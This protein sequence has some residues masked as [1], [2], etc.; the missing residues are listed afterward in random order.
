LEVAELLELARRD[1][2]GPAYLLVGTERFLVE[3]AIAAVR[4]A[5]LGDGPA[6]FN[7]DTF[8]GKGLSG[9]SVVGAARTLPMMAQKRFVLVREGDAMASSELDGLAAYLEGP[10]ESTC[11]LFV[12]EKLDGRTKLAKAAKKRGIVVEAVPLK[13]GALRAF[14]TREARARGHAL[15]AAAAEA[16]LE[17][18]GEDLAALDDAIERLSLYVGEGQPIDVAAVEACVLP[19]RTDSIWALVDGVSDRDG[20]RALRAAS[21]LLADREPPLRILAMVARQLRMIARMRQALAEGQAPQE[22]CR[23]AGA[24]PF[25]ARELARAAKR[26]SQAD[27]RAAFAAVA[28]ADRALK[29]SKRP[30]DVVLQEAVLRITQRAS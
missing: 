3:R 15:E 21:A 20:R 17:S 9:A 23:T 27:L 26:F 30:G 1:A 13:G 19:V 28:D 4:H 7:D 25:K 29:G 14:A 12:A 2:L 8:H 11:L 6:G 18:T 10:P 5:V 22:A 16:I 24:P